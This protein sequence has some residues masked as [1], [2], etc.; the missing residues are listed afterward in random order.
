LP[1]K[2]KRKSFGS[3]KT[4]EKAK[5]RVQDLANFGITAYNSQ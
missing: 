1:Y 3:Y 4:F 5:H 2:E